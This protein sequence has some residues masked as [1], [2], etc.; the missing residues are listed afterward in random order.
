MI[1]FY[2]LSADRPHMRSAN[3]LTG[4]ELRQLYIA[5]DNH[6]GAPQD[7]LQTSLSVPILHTGA[8]WFTHPRRRPTEAKDLAT[9]ST[10]SQGR[11]IVSTI[12]SQKSTRPATTIPM[13]HPRGDRSWT[14]ATT[15]TRPCCCLRPRL[16]TWAGWQP[17]SRC[18]K[19][20]ES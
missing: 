18:C 9:K 19:R 5:P 7:A 10:Q 20:K 17:P 11:R 3:I 15:S 14:L 12:V 4:Y 8:A 16:I 13:A 6:T 1:I 2:N